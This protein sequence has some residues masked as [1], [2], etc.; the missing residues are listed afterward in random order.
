MFHSILT[1]ISLFQK[2]EAKTKESVDPL[3]SNHEL[4]E[5]LLT[6][7]GNSEANLMILS[8]ALEPSKITSSDSLINEDD[9]S[10]GSSSRETLEAGSSKEITIS[11]DDTNKSGITTY[12]IIVINS[13]LF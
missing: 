13:Y 11:E 9:A 2:R 7:H 5:Y 8:Y 6:L 4:D 3:I 12:L 10:V 1:D